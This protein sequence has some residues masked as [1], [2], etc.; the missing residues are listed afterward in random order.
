VEEVRVENEG[1]GRLE[2]EAENPKVKTP[3]MREDGL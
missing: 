3:T 2:D 1:Y